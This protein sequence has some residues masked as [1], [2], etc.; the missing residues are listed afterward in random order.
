[1]EHQRLILF[2][3]VITKRCGDSEYCIVS[4]PGKEQQGWNELVSKGKLKK[5]SVACVFLPEH[6]PKS[7]KHADNP[8]CQGEK[9][10]LQKYR[11]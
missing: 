10:I 7:G 3:G 8:E 2:E 1:M 9:I 11:L 5:R 6:T 4:F